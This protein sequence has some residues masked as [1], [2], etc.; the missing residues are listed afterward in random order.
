MRQIDD[1]VGHTKYYTFFMVDR[2]M[3]IIA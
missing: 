3:R 2:M 1:F